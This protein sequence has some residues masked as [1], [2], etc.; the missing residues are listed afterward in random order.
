M[1]SP[2]FPRRSSL[3]GLEPL[4]KRLA[5]AG[6]V[7]FSDVDGDAV[8]VKSSKGTTADLQAAVVLQASGAGNQL[9][10]IDLTAA[11]F[12]GTTLSVT[13]KANGAGDGRVHVG[14]ID[15]TGRD[16]KAVTV[17][18]DLGRIRVGDSTFA[19]A[20]I[21]S[22]AVQSLG[23]YGTTTGAPNL[24]TQITGRA[25]S[26]TIAGN[27]EGAALGHAG[28]DGAWVSSLKIGGS[29]VEGYV[30]GRYKTVSI[31]ADLVGGA[32]ASSGNIDAAMKSISI[33]G[34]VIGSTG[35]LSGNVSGSSTTK[36]VIK[37]NVQGSSGA[38]SGMVRAGSIVVEGD[39]SGGAGILSGS[40][41]SGL[42][43]STVITVKGSIFGGTGDFSGWV[44]AETL[45]SISVGGGVTGLLTEPVGIS[46]RF[47]IGSVKI[48]QTFRRAVIRAGYGAEISP[49]GPYDSTKAPSV[50]T[51]GSVTI[52]GNCLESSIVAGATPG[53]LG[54]GIGDTVTAGSTE[55]SIGPIKIGGGVTENTA[56]TSYGFVGRSIKSLSIAGQKRPLPAPGQTASIDGTDVRIHLLPVSLG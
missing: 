13:A 6:V 33:A 30:T 5:L 14:Q 16:L 17:A 12:Q 52:G 29:M 3:F 50:A 27:V 24:Q 44:V 54:Y 56:L 15:A 18:G 23:A 51:I 45:K 47:S 31:G 26:I 46:A 34:D 21:A 10:A 7:T 32:A 11:V 48:G 55:C 36:V 39:V 22:L 38:F 35:I 41:G 1:E 20:A 40:I 4:E 8:T 53:P 28:S 49:Y 42:V 25:G 9:R 19:T 37:G 2:R 43:G